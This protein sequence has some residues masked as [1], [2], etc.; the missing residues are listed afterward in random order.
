[1]GSEESPRYIKIGKACTEKERKEIISLVHENKD[2]FAWSYD[3]LKT[4]DQN[5]LNHEIPLRADAKTFRQRLRFINPK[6]APTIQK[7]LQKQYE[8]KIIEHIRYYEWVS[9]VVAVRKKNGEIR[10]CIDFRNLNRACLKDN[11]PLS[12]MDHL[13]ETATCSEMMSTLEGFSGYNQVAMARKDRHK[14]TFV[15]PWG[16]YSYIRMPFGLINAS[17]TFQQAMDHAFTDFL[18]KFIVVYQD[19]I[20]MYS[21]KRYDHISHLCAT[22]DRC[23]KLGISLNPKKSFM[24]MFEAKL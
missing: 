8:A 22:F 7:E 17:V 1:V 5:V 14:T 21:K 15:T 4:F 24:G 9:N 18:F 16:T 11:Y 10:V 20:T 13:L 3:E 19:D 12:N 2:V 23:R 6:V